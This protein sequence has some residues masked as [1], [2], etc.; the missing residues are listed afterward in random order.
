MQGR[1]GRMWEIRGPLDLGQEPLGP[2]YRCEFGLE[3]LEPDLTLVLDVVCEID[4]RHP[5]LTE[6]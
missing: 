2:D 1:P 6:F 5:A 3:H 4:A